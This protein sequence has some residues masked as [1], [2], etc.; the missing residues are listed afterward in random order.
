M[1]QVNA[2]R[3]SIGSRVILDGLDLAVHPGEVCVLL[4]PN[5][6]GK[7]TLLKLLSG[8]L[9]N[10]SG[11]VLIDGRSLAQ[12]QPA[13]I[14]R[15]RAL[16][17]QQASLSFSFKVHEVVA[18]GR[19]PHGTN[20]KNAA[21]IQEALEA[22]GVAELRNRAYTQLSG[23]EQQRV[24]FARVLAQ[25]WDPAPD[26]SGRLLLLDE[27]VASL[28][29]AFQHHILRTTRQWAQQGTAV[30]VIL[31]DLNLAALYGDRLILLKNGRLARTG[32][33][34]E[35]LIPEAIYE[36]FQLRTTV[37]RH[38]LLDKPLVAP[39]LQ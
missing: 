1:L 36:V 2:L 17:P 14:A 4:G 24:H 26:A 18:M 38:P 19:H 3:Y 8:D 21:I 27:P 5:G 30:L 37:L 34:D 11:Q 23:G 25:I 32:S 7:S 39:T 31:H 22:A 10:Q 29:P 33:P 12:W 28:D 13:S 6:A 9:A 15:I 16:L 20:R 35:V